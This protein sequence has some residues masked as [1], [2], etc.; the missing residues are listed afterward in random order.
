MMNPG[1][2]QQEPTTPTNLKPPHSNQEILNALV[3]QAAAASNPG[4]A[5]ALMTHQARDGRSPIPQIG[6]GTRPSPPQG[7]LPQ[8]PS[9]PRGA[10]PLPGLS[11][12]FYRH[13]YIPLISSIIV[14]LI[15]MINASFLLGTW[16]PDFY[17]MSKEIMCQKMKQG[18]FIFIYKLLVIFQTLAILSLPMF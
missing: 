17:D 3:K 6:D 9:T 7:L 13:Y 15:I 8:P 5:A 16:F 10:S 11:F 1:L 12:I 2:V 14:N 4:M 18:I